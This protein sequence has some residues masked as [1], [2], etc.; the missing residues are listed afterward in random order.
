MNILPNLLIVDDAEEN[1]VYLENLIKNLKV[2]LIQAISGDEALEKTRGIELALAIIDVRMPVMNGYELALKMNEERLG[3]KVPVVFL[4]AS[5]VSETQVFE[6]YGSGAVDYIFKP[7]DNHVLLSKINVFLDLF[8]Q[9]Q[10][11]IRDA[12]QLK[13]S[14]DDLIR[15]NDTLRKSEEKYRSYVDHAPDGVFIIDEAGRYIEVNDEFLRASGYSRDEVIGSTS[16]ALKILNAADRKRLVEELKNVGQYAGLELNLNTK[17]G[18]ILTCIV[19]VQIIELEGKPHLLSTILDITPRKQ[20]EQEL[21]NEMMRLELL[22]SHMVNRELRMIELKKENAELKER[23]T[24]KSQ[25][26]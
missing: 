7:V 15:V 20:M 25:T 23:L 16:T 12:A 3:D 6:G 26:G 11:I 21:K 13:K 2:N 18:K 5:H 14:A 9:K 17:E 22:N 8:N 10:I 4:T 24:Q 19:N 1:L